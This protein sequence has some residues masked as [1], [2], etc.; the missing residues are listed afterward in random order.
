LNYGILSNFYCSK[1][2]GSLLAV[3]RMLVGNGCIV[4]SEEDECVVE[5]VNKKN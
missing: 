3:V 1:K 2:V 4:N 5:M